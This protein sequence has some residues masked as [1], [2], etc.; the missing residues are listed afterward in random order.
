MSNSADYSFVFSVTK[1]DLQ[2]T[3][4]DPGF[5]KP[6]NGRM[7]T[8]RFKTATGKDL[9]E[10]MQTNDVTLDDGSWQFVSSDGTVANADPR[11]GA[12][13]NCL[14]DSQSLP[15]IGPAQQANG[16]LA[17]DVPRTAGSLVFTPYWADGGWEWKIPAD[18]SSA[19]K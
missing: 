12:A 11:S 15:T 8:L 19:S 18:R 2:P 17:F 6:E 7:V 1:I 14:P 13:Y 9:A 3:C 4:V 16:S 10:V 5:S